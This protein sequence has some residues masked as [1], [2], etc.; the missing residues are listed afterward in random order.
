MKKGKHKYFRFKEFN[1]RATIEANQKGLSNH[2]EFELTE[3][4]NDDET[5]S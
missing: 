3:R 2:K 4:K 5:N 1:H